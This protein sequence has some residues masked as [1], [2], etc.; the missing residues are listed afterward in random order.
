MQPSKK[1]YKYTLLLT[2]G[3]PLQINP[4]DY[5]GIIRALIMAT[6]AIILFI[7]YI[8]TTRKTTQTKQK[9]ENKH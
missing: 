4:W 2:L 6:I 9:N 5:A 1:H 7:I 3:I 8:I